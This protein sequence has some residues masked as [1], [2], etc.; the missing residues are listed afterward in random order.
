MPPRSA[1]ARLPGAWLILLISV[2]C[3]LTLRDMSVAASS[4]AVVVCSMYS[5]SES[6]RRHLRVVS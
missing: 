3:P 4:E 6:E 2:L 1:C 5:S